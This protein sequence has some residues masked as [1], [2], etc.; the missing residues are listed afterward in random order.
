MNWRAIGAIIRKDL[1]AAFK[2]KAVLLPMIIVPLILVCLMPAAVTLVPQIIQS[3]GVQLSA[4][5]RGELGELLAQMPPAL[6]AELA[7]YTPA[8]A[9][10]VLVLTY[11]FAPLYLII[12]LMVAS[13]IAADSFAGE[14][15]RK[16]LEALL[17]SPTS[18]ADLLIAKL[19]VAWLPAVAV[20]LGSFLVYG[21]IVNVTAWPLIG[22]LFFPSPMWLLLAFW[23]GPAVAGLGLGVTVLVSA[24]VNTFQEAYQLGGLVVLP[25][26]MLLIG[27]VTG[28]F[29]LQLGFVALLGLCLWLLDGALL[30]WSARLLRRDAL[31]ARL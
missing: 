20:G 17:Y 22:R 18:D 21:V 11:L 10:T 30:W 27:Q 23:V 16:T 5:D 29:Y 4:D 2:S 28:L 24:R 12:P 9:V 6:R 31:L 7:R 8:Q 13:V 3:R 25:I 15:E 1:R 14:K 26:V 19:G